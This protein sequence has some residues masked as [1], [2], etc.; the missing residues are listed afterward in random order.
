MDGGYSQGG[1]S[2]LPRGGEWPLPTPPKWNPDLTHCAWL[3]LE[4]TTAPVAGA[5]VSLPQMPASP[6]DGRWPGWPHEP[7]PWQPLSSG[8]HSGWGT[9]IKPKKLIWIRCLLFK[10]STAV[11][12]DNY[13]YCYLGLSG[14]VLAAIISLRRA[15]SISRTI[16][17]CCTKISKTWR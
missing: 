6:D 4:L 8:G 7:S 16:D 14:R 2:Q 5:S 11:V 13:Y 15:S 12:F 10:A 1:G 3:V 17:S 9:Y